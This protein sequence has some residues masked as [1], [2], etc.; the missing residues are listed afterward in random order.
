MNLDELSKKNKNNIEFERKRNK[1]IYY[2]KL[3]DHFKE[4]CK[5]KELDETEVKQQMIRDFVEN[6]KTYVSEKYYLKY[7]DDKEEILV[8]GDDG[9]YFEL[10]DGSRVNKRTFEKM[11]KSEKTGDIEVNPYDF[12]NYNKIDIKLE[13]KEK[14]IEPINMKDFN[15]SRLDL[16][17]KI[18]SFF[19]NIDTKNM[20]EPEKKTNVNIKT[21]IWNNIPPKH[22]QNEEWKKG[23]KKE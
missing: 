22:N 7:Y 15:E 4:I 3:D 16:S 8:Y 14:P 18:K 10:S 6:N 11:F 13:K 12:F 17:K 20:K 1:T 23:T 19:D 5:V 21:P 2:G 9:Q